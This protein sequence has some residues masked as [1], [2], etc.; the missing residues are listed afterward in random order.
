M[1]ELD[2]LSFVLIDKVDED[3]GR[4]FGDWYHAECP[5]CRWFSCGL[6]PQLRDE[7]RLH[8]EEARHVALVVRYM[9]QRGGS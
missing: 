9:T 6:E 5:H 8:S 2:A 3:D 1:S 7:A 4:G